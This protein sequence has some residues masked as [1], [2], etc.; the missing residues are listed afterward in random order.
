MLLSERLG[1]P[2]CAREFA[3]A[4]LHTLDRAFPEG[5]GPPPDIGMT[6]ADGSEDEEEGED[7]AA[8]PTEDADISTGGDHGRQRASREG[9]LWDNMFAYALD[10]GK[11][12]VGVRVDRGSSWQTRLFEIQW[13]AAC[14]KLYMQRTQLYLDRC[15]RMAVAGGKSCCSGQT[16]PLRQGILKDALPSGF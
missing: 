8:A 6:A 16:G 5:Q 15:L 2:A 3:T 10:D 7:G 11:F 4:G 12:E 9:Q 14:L 13:L 1:L